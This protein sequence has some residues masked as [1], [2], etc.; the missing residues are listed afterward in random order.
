[1]TCTLEMKQKCMTNNLFA[2]ARYTLARGG[3][4]K[5]FAKGISLKFIL[6]KKHKPCVHTNPMFVGYTH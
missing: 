4:V 6:Y 2:L 1:M 3:L 5:V